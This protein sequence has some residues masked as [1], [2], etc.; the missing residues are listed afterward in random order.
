VAAQTGPAATDPVTVPEG[1]GAPVITDGIF[2]PGEWDDGL[3]IALNKTVTLHFKQ[4]RDV[5]FVGVRG[6]S[7]TAIG[8]SELLIAIPGGPVQKLHVS[9]QLY[10]IVMPASGPEPR[11]RFG[12]T[13][14]WY[15]NEFR[16]DMEEAGRLE[17]EGR[18]PI[19]I[20]LASGYPSEG[21]EFAIRRSKFAGQRWLVRLRASASTD[22]KPGAITYPPETLERTTDGWLDLRFLK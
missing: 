17:K 5:V 18:S 14:G 13:T 3:E 22:G 2:T 8:P 6:Q 12:L 7:P 1:N 19:E 21:I 9:A 16:R 15:A 11:P 10:E 4:F 20:M